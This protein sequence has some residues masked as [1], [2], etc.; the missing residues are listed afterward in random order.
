[1]EVH[2]TPELEGLGSSQT[3]ICL[4]IILFHALKFGESWRSD[5]SYVVAKVVVHWTT[6][7]EGLGSSH[8]EMCHL[9]IL[10]YVP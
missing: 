8:T 1:M 5:V 10:F 3:R 6:E 9:V 4:L 7:L 2:W